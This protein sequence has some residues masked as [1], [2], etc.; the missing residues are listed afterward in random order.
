MTPGANSLSQGDGAVELSGRGHGAHSPWQH[1]WLQRP[2]LWSTPSLPLAALRVEGMEGHGS[3]SPDPRM[4]EP[5]PL[6]HPRWKP[7]IRVVAEATSP[8]SRPDWSF[9][10]LELRCPEESLAGRLGTRASGVGRGSGQAPVAVHSSAGE[11]PQG[12]VPTELSPTRCR[13]RHSSGLCRV[14]WEV[15]GNPCQMPRDA[16]AQ[17]S[18]LP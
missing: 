16:G 6:C 12:P 13:C 3:P 8:S 14:S 4:P 5:L 1:C 11:C 7:T 17:L 15:M 2:V 10:R 9:L 18:G